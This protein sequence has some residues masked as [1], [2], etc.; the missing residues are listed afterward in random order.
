V[1]RAAGWAAVAALDNWSVPLRIA[2]A[3]M[4]LLTASAHWGRRRPDLIGMVPRVFPAPD[5]LVTATGVL[6]ILGAVGLLIPATVRPAAAGLAALLVVM[7]PANVRAA[8]EKLTIAGRPVPGVAVRTAMQLVFLAAII[9]AG[10]L[11]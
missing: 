4:F 5:L 3:L 7:F 6:E 8:R 10:V 1:L 11:N 9:A 2:L